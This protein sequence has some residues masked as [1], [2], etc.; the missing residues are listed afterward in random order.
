MTQSSQ[1]PARTCDPDN[2]ADQCL[3][4]L[5]DRAVAAGDE[6]NERHAL[7]ALIVSV[8]PAYAPACRALVERT[9]GE[10]RADAL[11]AGLSLA[12][13]RWLHAEIHPVSFAPSREGG[14]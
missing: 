14:E 9:A 8:H 10:E 6:T 12:T 3:H 1:T 5:L 11:I 4:R 7:L 2:F 13:L